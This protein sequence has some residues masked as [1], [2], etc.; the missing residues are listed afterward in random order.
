VNVAEKT[1][2]TTDKPESDRTEELVQHG[3][4]HDP[5][6]YEVPDT[7]ELSDE[8]E[9]WLRTVVKTSDD[10]QQAYLDGKIDEDQ[11]AKA[12]GRYGRPINPSEVVNRADAAYEKKLPKWVFGAP[13]GLGLTMEQR[14]KE[15]QDVEKDRPLTHEQ[16]VMLP[17]KEQEKAAKNVA[18]SNA[19]REQEKVTDEVQRQRTE[20]PKTDSPSST[21]PNKNS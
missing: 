4:P 3:G 16:L 15:T 20:A 13:E 2:T 9:V 14:L 12:I 21:T 1:A 18:K 5:K 6:D 19:Q 10:A 11:L 17:P 7:G 8:D